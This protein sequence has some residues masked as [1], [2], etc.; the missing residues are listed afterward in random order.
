MELLDLGQRRVIGLWESA[1]Q[2]I[3]RKPANAQRL[4]R[5]GGQCGVRIWT[6]GCDLGLEQSRQMITSA[7]LWLHAGV[8][9]SQNERTR[10]LWQ[11]LC[12]QQAV[13]LRACL[14]INHYR[15]PLA[16]IAKDI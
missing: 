5:I 11:N 3:D 6:V 2:K 13:E 4:V 8:A 16:R 10:G 9:D 12:G 15:R 1:G 7:V 14:P